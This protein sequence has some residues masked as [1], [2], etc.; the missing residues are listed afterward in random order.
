MTQENKFYHNIL[1][2][3]LH[4]TSKGLHRVGGMKTCEGLIVACE[5][6]DPP[7]FLNNWLNIHHRTLKPAVCFYSIF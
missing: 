5:K 6:L 2:I 7:F 1:Y 4:A 3:L